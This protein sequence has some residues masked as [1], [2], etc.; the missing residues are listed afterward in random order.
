MQFAI[1]YRKLIRIISIF[2][3]IFSV[4]NF[5][6]LMSMFLLKKKMFKN[7]RKVG[8]TV[9]SAQLLFAQFDVKK[10]VNKY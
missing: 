7:L 5:S 3:D 1:K 9:N 6:Y 8:N 2:K 4:A 10:G